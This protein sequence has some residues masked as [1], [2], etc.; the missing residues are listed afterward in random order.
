MRI[1]NVPNYCHLKIIILSLFNFTKTL[2]KLF[3]SEVLSTI[4]EFDSSLTSVKSKYSTLN[5]NS[6]FSFHYEKS[7]PLRTRLDETLYDNLSGEKLI[8]LRYSS[9]C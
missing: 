3:S 4:S 2:W 9:L 5:M 1:F 6:A 7:A 8:V